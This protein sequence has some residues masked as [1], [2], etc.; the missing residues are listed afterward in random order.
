MKRTA[1]RGGVTWTNRTNETISITGDTYR[2]E[3]KTRTFH[4]DGKR[5]NDI[6]SGTTSAVRVLE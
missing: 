2:G 3:W 1:E 5:V 6:E 4:P